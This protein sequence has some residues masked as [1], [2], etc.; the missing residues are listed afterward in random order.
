[1]KRKPVNLPRRALKKRERSKKENDG[2]RDDSRQ[3]GASPT[4][5]TP[6]LL[7]WPICKLCKKEEVERD[8]YC[9]ICLRRLY[10]QYFGY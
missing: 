9:A 6:T 3:V 7:P 1:M 8:D 5:P 4:A 2:G 10:K